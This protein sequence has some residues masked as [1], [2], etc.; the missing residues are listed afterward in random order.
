MS[1]KRV[2][3]K[4]RWRNV[5]VAFRMSPEEAEELNVKVA[6]SGLSKQDY[7]IQCL[8]KHEIRVV[9]G[10]KV[11]RKVEMYLEAVL[12]ELQCM[13]MEMQDN[14]EAGEKTDECDSPKARDLD[15]V[16]VPLRHIL[17]IINADEAE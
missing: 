3:A 16:I 15:D 1:E 17:K 12:E 7:I 8:L 10:R 9:G 11:A 14:A 6:I 2:D 13:E 5:V 4:N